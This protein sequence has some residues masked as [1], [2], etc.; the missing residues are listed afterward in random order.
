MPWS[1]GP[2]FFS[3]HF[4]LIGLGLFFGGLAVFYPFLLFPASR[5]CQVADRD[6]GCIAIWCCRVD[7]RNALHLW[8]ISKTRSFVIAV[9]LLL[10]I[11][12]VA[13]LVLSGRIHRSGRHGL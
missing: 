10:P 6:V 7:R 11:L 5:P 1:R 8:I 9:C 2:I 12:A 4:R 3:L 13:D